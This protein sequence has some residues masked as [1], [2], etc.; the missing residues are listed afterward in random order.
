MP[1]EATFLRVQDMAKY[2]MGSDV[3]YR[4]ALGWHLKELAEA[5]RVIEKIDN[6]DGKPGDELIYIEK[7]LPNVAFFTAHMTVAAQAAKDLLENLQALG[8]YGGQIQQ[9]GDL[10]KP[11]GGKIK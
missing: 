3:P 5:L 7:V 1:H 8:N 10:S 4:K 2:L 11:M 6:G 9:Y